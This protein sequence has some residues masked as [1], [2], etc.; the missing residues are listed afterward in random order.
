VTQSV[1]LLVHFP[2]AARAPS[3]DAVAALGRLAAIDARALFEILQELR[4][5]PADITAQF[6]QRRVGSHGYE[7]LVELAKQAP[8]VADAKAASRQLDATVQ[9]ILAVARDQ[10]YA[11]LLKLHAAGTLKPDESEELQALMKVPPTVR[12][13]PIK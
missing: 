1:R 9:K 7:R 6:L 11:A 4:S 12:T 8:L 5:Q 2:S 10:R 13:G 3:D